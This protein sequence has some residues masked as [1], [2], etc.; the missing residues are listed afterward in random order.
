V[1][2]TEVKV[3]GVLRYADEHELLLNEICKRA[4]LGVRKASSAVSGL[5][6]QGFV[7]LDRD[8][9]FAKGGACSV[10]VRLCR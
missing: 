10:T 3:F 6:R 1:N 9:R 2:P 5:Q 4:Q 7:T 8:R